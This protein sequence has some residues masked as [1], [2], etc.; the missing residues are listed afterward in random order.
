M[1][2]LTPYDE[3]EKIEI[4]KI[5]R[6]EK[7]ILCHLNEVVFWHSHELWRD[8][9]SYIPCDCGSASDL[10]VSLSEYDDMLRDAFYD[11]L[12]QILTN[13]NLGHLFPVIGEFLFEVEDGLSDFFQFDETVDGEFYMSFRCDAG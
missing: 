2:K 5:S 6:S 4:V 13:H 11:V 8:V 7:E 3:F 1:K 12:R 9:H 10:K